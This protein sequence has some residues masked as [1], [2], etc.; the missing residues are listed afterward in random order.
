MNCKYAD[1]KDLIREAVAIAAL[2]PSIS[3]YQ[4]TVK[5]VDHI[6]FQIDKVIKRE[7]YKISKIYKTQTQQEPCT[8]S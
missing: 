6:A 3:M 4:L 5:E 1:P 7:G 8:T 2:D